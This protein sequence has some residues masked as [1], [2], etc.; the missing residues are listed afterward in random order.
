MHRHVKRQDWNSGGSNA[1]GGGSG[2][3]GTTTTA[4]GNGGGSAAATTTQADWQK[5]TTTS[6]WQAPSSTTQAQWSATTTTTQE[7]VAPSSSST[8]SSPAWSQ[9]TTTT[10]QNWWTS[11]STQ[12]WTPSSSS[13]QQWTPSS[14]S[15]QAWSSSTQAWTS[16]SSTANWWDSTSA[17]TTTAAWQQQTSSSSVAASSTSLPAGQ[18]T[19]TSHSTAVVVV[20][21]SAS[22]S[23][24]AAANSLAANA[25]RPGSGGSNKIATGAVAGI[26]VGALIGVAALAGGIFWFLKKKMRDNEPDMVSPF[27]RDAFRRASVMLDNDDDEF[28]TDSYRNAAGA[29]YTSHSPHM[30]EYSMQSLTAAAA[31]GAM[32]SRGDT[33]MRQHQ[34][35]Q[36]YQQQPAFD[37]S[38]VVPVMAPPA[39][40]AG[41][42]GYPAAA[43]VNY[44]HAGPAASLPAPIPHGGEPAGLGAYPT[45]SR[46]PSQVSRPAE[47]LSPGGADLTRRDSQM[48]E[49]SQY[50]DGPDGNPALAIPPVAASRGG[51]YG[52]TDERGLPLVHE[53]EEPYTPPSATNGRFADFQQQQLDLQQRE[54][55]RAHADAMLLAAAHP[56][57]QSRSGTPENANVQQTFFSSSHESQYGDADSQHR[58][59]GP[60]AG[61]LP[62]DYPPFDGQVAHIG[63]SWSAEAGDDMNGDYAAASS[64]ADHHLAGGAG[65]QH[66]RRLS[67]R[68]GGLD[69]FDEEDDEQ[70]RAHSR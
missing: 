10:T 17:T 54:R 2:A 70:I 39:A 11:S 62:A 1:S 60:P 12:Q 7:W 35:P 48:S 14:S 66:R 67:V 37:P 55:E 3:G 56:E 4:A 27:D 41:A 28:G 46:G 33:L 19:F 40:Y 23:N 26:V 20:D 6:Q 5:T 32:V 16:S 8:W 13:T 65:Q 52:Y 45:L 18:A 24:A 50:S 61:A 22:A 43:A 29:G 31:G 69:D 25:A 21:A 42:A 9:A 64:A 30:S 59:S 15:T 36:V 63:R 58:L 57:G 53:V 49:Y 68:N 34:S 44:S 51:A 47:M 38:Q